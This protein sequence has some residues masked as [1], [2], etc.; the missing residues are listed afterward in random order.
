MSA[1]KE[2]AEELIVQSL[3]EELTPASRAELDRLLASQPDLRAEAAD[4]KQFIERITAEPVVYSGD[5][6]PAVMAELSRRGSRR[7]VPQWLLAAAAFALVGGG[8]F[9][10]M[11]A[12]PP[13]AVA[14]EIPVAE[15]TTLDNTVP[16]DTEIAS[17]IASR[18][19]A[20]AYATLEARVQNAPRGRDAAQAVQTMA[21]VAFANLQWYD[22]AFA[23][24][25]RLRRD[26][27]EQFRANETNFVRLNLLDEA[28]GPAGDY[29]SLRALDAAR[30]RGKTAAYENILAKYPATY[31]ASEAAREYA[32]VVARA[33]GVDASEYTGVRALQMAQDQAKDPVAKQQLRIE[34]AHA[35]RADPAQADE[36]RRIYTEIADGPYTTL[37][38]LAKKS[39]AAMDAPQA[40]PEAAPDAA[41]E[42]GL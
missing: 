29:A 24:Y 15:N 16:A 31:V 9:Y 20:Q 38:Q 39:L 18:E 2:R 40:A 33:Q 7:F 12:H 21:D 14:P 6:R 34:V 35:L 28:R 19:Y 3:H 11:A 4:L 22:E 23:G 30:R 27:V 36:A 42:P 1:E 17:L 13:A 8:V 41:G 25:D 10:W 37:A 5:L 32:V 26:Y